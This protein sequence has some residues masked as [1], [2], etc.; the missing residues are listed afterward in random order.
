MDVNILY[1][2]GG[3]SGAVYQIKKRRPVDEG[4]Q[5]NVILSAFG[6]FPGMRLVIV[7]DERYRHLLC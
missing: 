2:V 7:V 6:T 4:Y 3:W 5:Q 1:G